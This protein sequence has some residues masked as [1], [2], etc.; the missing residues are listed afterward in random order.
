MAMNLGL[1]APLMRRHLERA[2][3]PGPDCVILDDLSK[4]PAVEAA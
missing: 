4:A 2:G 3:G 1:Q